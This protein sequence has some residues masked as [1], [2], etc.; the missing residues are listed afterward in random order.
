MPAAP[1]SQTQ[2]EYRETGT[3][4][5]V[6][7]VHGTLGD[8]RSWDP[9]VEALAEHH[10]VISYSRRHHHPNRCCADGPAYSAALHAD[11]LVELM[12]WLGVGPAH[13]VGSSYGAY[14]ALFLAARH[15][16]RVRRL[17]LSEPP[18]L[19]LLEHHPEGHALREEFLA[20]VWGP[21]GRSMQRGDAEDGVRIFVDGL[22][23]DGAW[24]DLTGDVR[25]LI[26]DNACEFALET[27]S[28]DFWTA[29]TCADAALVRAPTLLL[30]GQ[31]SRRM[32]QLVV[33]E[34]D[35]WLPDSAHVPFPETSHDLPGA[36][37]ELFN[38]VVLS[39]LADDSA[40]PGAARTARP[41]S[42]L[43]TGTART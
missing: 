17:V 9:Q 28:P 24:A 14:T 1:V 38:E 43:H 23:G 8:L 7:L 27:G 6:I 15:P 33:E 19:P 3:G 22:F 31:Q 10:R 2:L 32:F 35:R 42:A 13:V 18:V 36:A 37:S 16:E 11:D 39:F 5:P 29:F 20:T 30:S 40:R 34:L 26:M 41:L 4:D 21:A 25:Q 12:T